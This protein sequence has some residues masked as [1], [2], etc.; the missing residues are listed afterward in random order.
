MVKGIGGR[1]GK[2]NRGRHSRIG[3]QGLALKDRH[4]RIGT[5]GL[6]LKD[7]HSR[8]GWLMVEGV[9]YR[10]ASK[11]H[12]STPSPAKRG[13]FYFPVSMMPTCPL[14]KGCFTCNNHIV[15]SPMQIVKECI[16]SVL[17][18]EK[19]KGYINALTYRFC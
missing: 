14:G 4:S 11:C 9:L 8:I 5:Q 10:H 15:E 1:N 17:R 12:A 7:R 19:N 13:V 3:T 2:G 16:Q 18:V 6:A